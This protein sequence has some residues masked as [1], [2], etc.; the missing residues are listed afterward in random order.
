ML[1]VGDGFTFIEVFDL[2]RRLDSFGDAHGGK[3]ALAAGA[4]RKLLPDGYL[5]GHAGER[6]QQAEQED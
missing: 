6:G 5:S 2:A 1:T 4:L 3:Y